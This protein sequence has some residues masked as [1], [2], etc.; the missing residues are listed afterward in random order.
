[1]QAIFY[2]RLKTTLLRLFRRKAS[3]SKLI[4]KMGYK[5]WNN[6]EKSQQK[7]WHKLIDLVYIKAISP[8]MLTCPNCSERQFHYFFMRARFLDP[9][10]LSA[11]DR[12]GSWFWCSNCRLFYHFSARVPEWWID[13]AVPALNLTDYPE[14]LDSNLEKWET[15]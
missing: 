4:N 8:R 12:G 1:M 13:V 3:V 15:E 10:F 14:W 11:G 6:P 2:F 7:D 5:D 9:Q